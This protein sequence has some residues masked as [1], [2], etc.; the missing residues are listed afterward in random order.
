[1]NGVWR[2]D[3]KQLLLAI[4]PHPREHFRLKL[5]AVGL[6]LALWASLHTG[7]PSLLP[8]MQSAPIELLNIPPDLA[9]SSEVPETVDVTLRGR[10]S[11]IGAVTSTD[12][13]VRIDLSDGHAGEN[14][15]DVMD[16]VS[17]PSDFEVERVQP[18]QL[19]II[20]EEEVEALRP[21]VSVIEGEPAPGYEV[22]SRRLDPESARI[23]GPRSRVADVEQ[24]RTEAVNITG[25]TESFSQQ[26]ALQADSSFV[27]LPEDREVQLNI[28]IREIP[29]VRDFQGLQVEVINSPYRVQV[30][31]EIIG[32]RLRGPPSVLD[33]L[34]V[35]DLRAVIDAS[36]LEPQA[37]DYLVTP[38]IRFEAAELDEEALTLE[39][40][41]P[42]RR[43]NVHVY[44][45]PGG[46][47][48]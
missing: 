30:N 34:T 18:A 33:E 38:Q 46:S 26:V 41:L 40:I 11:R 39:E 14:L 12:I 9:L 1:M 8:A 23:R 29:E 24:L 3:W 25:R 27:T 32:V 16:N 22:S 47:P 21:V 5:I 17:V 15:V 28:E 44:D 48:S 19:R 31:P 7:G 35:D 45:T 20:L 6:A 13:R 42:Q 37:E 4:E 2:L 36:G 43:L 10:Q